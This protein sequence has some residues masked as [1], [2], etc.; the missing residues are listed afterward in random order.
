MK[1]EETT[2]Y[3]LFQVTLKALV[4]QG[5]KLLILKDRGQAKKWDL[6][7]GRIEEKDLPLPMAEALRR[8][9][10]EE[11]GKSAEISIGKMFYCSKMK[12]NL[13]RH[14]HGLV[15]M[16]FLAKYFGGALKLSKEHDA[17]AWVDRESYKKYKFHQHLKEAVKNFFESASENKK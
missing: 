15:V 2:P 7:G 5:G 12:T 17:Y 11:L 6:P 1:K 13:G 14:D 16:V 3:K 8:E 10:R 9:L 4:S